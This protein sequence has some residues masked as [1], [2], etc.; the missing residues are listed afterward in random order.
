MLNI[1]NIHEKAFYP[2]LAASLDSHKA[3]KQTLQMAE[4]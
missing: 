4:A 1:K 2:T 3:I